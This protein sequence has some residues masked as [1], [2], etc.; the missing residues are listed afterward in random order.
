M[1]VLQ[2]KLDRVNV[3]LG[4]MESSDK[5]VVERELVKLSRGE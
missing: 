3:E 2:E 4:I 1:A 5:P